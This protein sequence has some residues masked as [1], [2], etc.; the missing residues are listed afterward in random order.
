MIQQ[1]PAGVPVPQN[2]RIL[3]RNKHV[4]GP[5]LALCGEGRRKAEGEQQKHYQPV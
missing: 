3:Q 4:D 5:R 1:A 2:P